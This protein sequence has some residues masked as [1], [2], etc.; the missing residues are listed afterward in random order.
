M[1]NTEN[2]QS[3]IRLSTVRET[4]SEWEYYKKFIMD[5]SMDDTA[6]DYKYFLSREG[7]YGESV[8]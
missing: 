5:L 1:Y 6:E 2:R 4:I 8:E 7:D 3:K